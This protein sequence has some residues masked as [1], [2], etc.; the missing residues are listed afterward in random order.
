MLVARAVGPAA[1][2]GGWES[3]AALDLRRD[4]ASG[5]ESREA[6]CAR[7][8]E[9]ARVEAGDECDRW[10][11]LTVDVRG[12]STPVRL[13]G[14]DNPETVASNQPIGCYGKKA[15][16]YTKQTLTKR[17][18]RLEIPCV[19]DSEDAYG[20]TLAY[21]YPDTDG[22]GECEHLYNGDLIT[23]GLA[24]TT[25][26]SHAYRREFERLREYAEGSRLVERLS[27]HGAVGE[28]SVLR[29]HSPFELH[30]AS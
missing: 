10:R 26:L 7:V 19:G 13:I 9:E 28:P 18:F 29:I 30:N 3:L 16:E 17:I 1:P 8:A 6:R 21:V 25:T 15:S 14:V 11:H 22:D 12:R 2:D 23:L 5:Q 20:R 24:R 27:Q 4:G